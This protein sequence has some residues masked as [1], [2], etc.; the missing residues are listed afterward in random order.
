MIGA[1]ALPRP[2]L[3]GDA[4]SFYRGINLNGPALVIDGHQ[5]EA[6]DAKAVSCEDAAFDNQSV[7]LAPTTDAAR[8]RMIRSSRWSPQG[9]AHVR[10]SDIPAN[11]Y[12]VYLYLWED[13][14][15]QAFDIALSGRVVAKGY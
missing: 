1:A 12:S 3:A 4:P 5:W 2:A 8:A 7:R 10:V 14:D 9:K 15:P 11:T 13:N 6:G